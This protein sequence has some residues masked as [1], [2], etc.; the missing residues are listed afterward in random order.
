MTVRPKE[1]EAIAVLADAAAGMDQHVIADQ[2]ALDRG[3][4]ADIAI[5][6]D[7]DV[8]PDYGAGADHRAGADLDIGADH[9]QRID[10]DAVLQTRA[11]VD[12]GGRRDP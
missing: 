9:G 11:G 8:G 12:D 1:H 4:C 7:P 2:R 5:A 3:P 10:H 6:A